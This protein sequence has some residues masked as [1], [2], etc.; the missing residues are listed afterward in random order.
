MIQNGTPF[1]KISTG[2]IAETYQLHFVQ[3]LIF[4][5]HHT[6]LFPHAA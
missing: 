5:P 3:P 2:F 1:T 4:Y 6:F